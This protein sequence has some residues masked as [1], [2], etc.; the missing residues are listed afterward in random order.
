MPTDLATTVLFI[1]RLLLGGAFLVFGLRNIRSIPALTGALTGR[2]LP[3]PRI[4]AMIG[5]G[6]QIVGGLL[7]A[8]GPWSLVGGVLLIVFL[9]L[10]TLLFHPFW[11]YEGEAR[12]PHVNAAIM[13]T[14]LTGAFLLVIATAL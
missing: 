8:I 1:A 10:A 9:V 5:V 3:L 7:V 2:R 11:E 4:C 14:G 12:G 13:N 6:L